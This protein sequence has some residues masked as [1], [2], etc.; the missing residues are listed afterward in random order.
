M[1]AIQ[2]LATPHQDFRFPETVELQ[3]AAPLQHAETDLDDAL[4][5]VLNAVRQSKNP[6]A[7]NAL[8]TLLA[9]MEM[10][11]KKQTKPT[12]TDVWVTLACPLTMT[13]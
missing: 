11:E 13:F 4:A 8:G 5:V 9:Y 12:G 10:L 6:S 2:L 3:V 7:M 1:Q